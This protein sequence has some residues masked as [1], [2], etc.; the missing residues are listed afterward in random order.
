M[1]TE[2]FT[3]RLQAHS[4]NQ[5]ELELVI[6]AY[7]GHGMH[8]AAQEIH[9]GRAHDGCALR[10]L[11]D[12][13]GDLIKVLAG[14]DLQPGDI[15]E[16]EKKITAEIVTPGPLKVRRRV[17]F[18]SV[19]TEG[20]FRYENMFQILPV[21]PEAPRPKY[22]R[23][24]HPLFLELAV[25]TSPNVVIS[26]LRQ[27]RIGRQLEQ[28]LSSLLTFRLNGIGPQVRHQW[29]SF[30][31]SDNTVLLPSKFLQEGYGW[32]GAVGELAEFSACTEYPA[33]TKI[34]VQKYY[35]RRGI[36]GGQTLEVP[37]DIECQLDQFFALLPKQKEKFLRASYWFQHA[38]HAFLPSRSACFVALVSAIEALVPPTTG[39][40]QC[41]TCQQAVGA[42]PTKRFIDFVDALSPGIDESERKRFYRLRSAIAHGGK[43]L[44][45]DQGLFWGF[46][47]QQ[48]GEGD[49]ISSMWKIVQ[50]VLCNWLR[51][52]KSRVAK[53]LSRRTDVAEKDRPFKVA[54]LREG[55][56][57]Y[58]FKSGALMWLPPAVWPSWAWMCNCRARGAFG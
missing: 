10:V 12:D 56:Y 31:P 27:E 41:P 57:Q 13:S 5:A 44:L 33:L 3:S 8:A 47:P 16:L 22:P 48:L 38:H 35:A 17:L 45:D 21:P 49:D 37:L 30:D 20:T 9:H 34:D 55:G 19:P 53:T 11:Y 24:E 2:D 15:E 43:L 26:A 28:V 52:Q 18:S 58:G 46:T 25:Q 51:A 36:G 7:F 50:T 42:G 54:I 14:P 4:L 29:C 39:G 23:G 6:R 32:D 1:D 40:K